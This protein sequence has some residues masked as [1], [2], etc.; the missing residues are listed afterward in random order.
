[1]AR[2]TNP[3]RVKIWNA[4]FFDAWQE[5]KAVH[6][7]KNGPSR[8]LFGSRQLV[9]DED[10]RSV[11]FLLAYCT[12]AIEARANHLIDELVEKEKITD[13]ESEA[14]QKL[15]AGAKW[16]LLPRLAGSRKKLS[17]KKAPHQA[18][19]EICARRNAL[20][21]VNFAKLNKHLP[22]PGKMLS[23]FRDFVRAMEDMNVVLGRTR[24]HRSRVQSLGDFA[25]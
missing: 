13:E 24:R 2:L 3:D 9:L 14:A 12:L 18:V 5:A 23:L 10:Q 20:V 8:K 21:H 1:M 16:F 19:A 6:E 15:S 4:F 7:R 22:P 25:K 11:L 17:S